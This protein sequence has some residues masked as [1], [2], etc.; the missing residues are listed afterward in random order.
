MPT[1]QILKYLDAKGERLDSDIAQAIGMSLQQARVY[2][3]ELT[4]SGKI[5]SCLSIKYE[6]GKKIEAISCRIV[7]HIPKAAPGRKSKVQLTLS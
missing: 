1:N 2:L 7:G 6:K 3:A 4:S 5:M